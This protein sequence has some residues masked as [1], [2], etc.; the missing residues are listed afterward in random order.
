MSKLGQIALF[1]TSIS[2]MISITTSE[3]ATGFDKMGANHWTLPGIQLLIILRLSRAIVQEHSRS[4][5]PTLR[6]TLKPF[7][8]IFG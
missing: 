2:E 3:R 1:R 6:F 4:T 7:G 8:N 5:T